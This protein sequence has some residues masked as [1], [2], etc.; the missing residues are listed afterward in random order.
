VSG[1]REC[2]TGRQAGSRCSSRTFERCV[3]DLPPILGHRYARHSSGHVDTRASNDLGSEAQAHIATKTVV[4]K[5]P[6]VLQ[7]VGA[8]LEDGLVVEDELVRMLDRGIESNLHI[9]TLNQ[10]ARVDVVVVAAVAMDRGP[11]AARCVRLAR[12]LDEDPSILGS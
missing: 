11:L 6:R 1:T 5:V 2:G 3:K 4:R 12:Y 7:Y 8:Q 10:Y 9:A